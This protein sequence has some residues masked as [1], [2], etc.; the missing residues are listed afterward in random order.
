MSN[1]VFLRAANVGGKNVF[2]PAQVA[3]ALKHLD[4]VNVGAAGTF[5]VRGNVSTAEIRREIL[6]HLAFDPELSV[7]PAREILA[8]VRSEPFRRVAFSK[9]LRGW[10]AV[11]GGRPAARP[12]LPLSKPEGKA[13]SVRLDRIEGA[14]ALGLWRRRPD[15]SLFPNQ[16]V[17]STLRVRAT[18]RFWET[19]LRLAG[20]IEASR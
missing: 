11:L 3:A 4:V 19:I 15:A 17:E 20:L 14:F 8:L 5:L 16:V 9:D 13:W 1:V 2:R 12:T 18:T 10:V 6:A 7:R